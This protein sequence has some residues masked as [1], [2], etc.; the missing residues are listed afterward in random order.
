M[1]AYPAGPTIAALLEVGPRWLCELIACMIGLRLDDEVAD[2]IDRE[3][4]PDQ[5]PGHAEHVA[6]EVTLV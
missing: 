1:Y 4:Y 3:G 5:I 2:A 6:I